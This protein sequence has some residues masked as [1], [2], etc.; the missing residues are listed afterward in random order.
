VATPVERYENEVMVA[1]M[2][3]SGG[4]F[5]WWES[6]VRQSVLCWC[7]L[8]EPGFRHRDVVFKFTLHIINFINFVLS[9]RFAKIMLQ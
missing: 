3:E 4:V 9:I 7:V 5:V 1:P 8:Q 6:R 2:M